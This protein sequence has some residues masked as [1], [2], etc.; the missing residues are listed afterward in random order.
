MKFRRIP[1]SVPLRVLGVSCL[2]GLAGCITP[3]GPNYKRP[4][5][6]LPTTWRVDLPQAAEV[7]NTE[8]WRAFGDENLNRLIEQALIANSDLLIATARVE[9]FAARLE[10]THS[11]YYPQLG[12]DLGY[13]RDQRSE[14]IPEILRPGQP[15]TY[16][17][18]KGLLTISYEFD[19]W[20]RVRR[21][22]EG[23]RAQLLSQEQTR[24]GVMLTVVTS[25]AST[26]FELLA[27]DRE[28]EIAEQTLAS[29]KSSWDLT[30]RK[31]HGGSATDISVGVMNAQYEDQA[32]VIPDVEH[33]IAFLEDSLSELLGENP[34]AIPRGHLS[35]LQL[36]DI[37]S[38]IPGHV[39]TRRP[40]V[41]AA[42]QD[43]VAA[44][45]T[46]GIA[47]TEYFPT[48]SLTG[49][50]G[51]ASDMTQWL[52]AKT[53]R[54]GDLALDLVGPIFTFGR[55]EGDVR[56]ARAETKEQELHYLQTVQTALKEVNDALVFSQQSRIRYNALHRHVVARQSVLEITKM[57]YTGGSSTDLDVFDADREVYAAQNE[58]LSGRLDEY[59]ALVSVFKAMGGGW[60]QGEDQAHSAPGKQNPGHVSASTSGQPSNV[61]KEV[62]AP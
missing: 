56:K 9:Q 19:I 14:E 22:N 58:E 28:L 37:P 35:Q 8:W 62:N 27:A 6:P 13:E 30:D 39:L 24:H 3:M 29:W 7:A 38:D 26:Y 48:F 17:T 15:P 45:A 42:E 55:V 60:M 43:L 59:L 51:Q 57:R 21:A 36:M 52:L 1:N 61:I 10:T 2:L 32:A 18:F 47:K 5:V 16:N 50:Y 54:T 44:N 41:M 40:D 12:T 4:A 49:Y 11:E 34:G 20:G 46:I 53:A 33:R 23:A 25:V 31:F